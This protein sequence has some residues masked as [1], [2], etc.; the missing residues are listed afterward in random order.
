M[1]YPYRIA[2]LAAVL[3]AALLATSCGPSNPD[4]GVEPT[5][6]AVGSGPPPLPETSPPPLPTLVPITPAPG[7]RERE[8]QWRLASQSDDGRRLL[9]DVAIG[10]PPCDTVTGVDV[11]ETETSVTV[12]VYAGRLKS[13][14][15]PSGTAGSLATAKVEAKLTRPLA[16]R[17]LLGGAS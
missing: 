11:K 1:S 6:A 3:G 9:V 5:G 17:K 16:D 15:C 13:A 10:G 7:R 12:T 14:D 8:A 4:P 2:V